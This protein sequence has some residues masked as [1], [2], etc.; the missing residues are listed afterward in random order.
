MEG[1]GAGAI[2]DAAV[3]ATGFDDFGD[4]WFMRPLTARSADLEQSNL[5]RFGRQFL[6]R[7]G[8]V[9]DLARRP[10]VLETLR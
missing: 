9:R 8:A 3:A 6:A 7:V 1:A 5:T 4:E 2:R 10:R